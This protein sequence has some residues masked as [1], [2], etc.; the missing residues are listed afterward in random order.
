MDDDPRNACLFTFGPRASASFAAHR[1]L[2]VEAVYQLLKSPARSAVVLVFL[3]TLLTPFA[4][5]LAVSEGVRDQYAAAV[6]EGPDVYITGDTYGS[7]APLPVSTADRIAALHGVTRVVPRVIGRTYTQGTFLAILGIDPTALPASIRL[8]EGHEPTAGGDVMI[9]RRAAKYL[10]IRVGSQ[11]S[12]SRKSDLTFRVVGLF[13]SPLTAWEADLMVMSFGDAADL[14]GTPDKATDL[15][16]WTR[17]GYERIIDAIVRLP[18]EEPGPLL[19]VQTK[20]LVGRYTQRGFNVRAGIFAGFYA[21]VLGLGIPCI[22]VISGLGVS[23]RRRETG[24]MKALGWQT[25]EVLEMVAIEHLIVGL[26]SVPLIL[27]A[28]T[29]WVDLLGARGL[30]VFFVPNSEIMAPFPIPW[31]LFPVPALPVGMLALVL[32]MVGGLYSTWRAAV[33]PPAE[34]MKT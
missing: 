13:E 23:E 11:F 12:L 21:I 6:R 7:N 19:R 2:C 9:G 29:A 28:A 1:A 17:P 27:V 25:R 22:G 24:V 10:R 33:V 4:A 20:D 3:V 18:Q 8:V 30:K 34:A 32:T 5:G 14:F 15:M 31:R 16:V 26:V